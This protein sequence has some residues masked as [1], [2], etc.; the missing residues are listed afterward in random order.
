MRFFIRNHRSAVRP[1][2]RSGLRAEKDR[3]AR[4]VRR[5]RSL[6]F[7]CLSSIKL[8]LREWRM[9]RTRIWKASLSPAVPSDF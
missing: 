5:L 6:S 7:S 4:A 9:D 1:E 3:L 2:Q 8:S